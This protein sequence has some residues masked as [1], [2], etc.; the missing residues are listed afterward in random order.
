MTLLPGELVR[1]MT[2]SGANVV[3]CSSVMVPTV[4]ESLNTSKE[5][6]EKIKVSMLLSL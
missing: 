6:H 5:L 2:H 3:F 4:R 1:Q